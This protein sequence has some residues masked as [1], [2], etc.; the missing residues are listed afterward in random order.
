L[1]SNIS[2]KHFC[3]TFAVHCLSARISWLRR[4]FWPLV[5]SL[6]SASKGDSMHSNL[7]REF[8]KGNVFDKVRRLS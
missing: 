3:S 4:W 7:L 5:M 1:F 8:N 2:S 6:S